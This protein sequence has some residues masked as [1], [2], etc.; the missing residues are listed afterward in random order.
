MRSSDSKN[1]LGNKHINNRGACLSDEPWT[2]ASSGA[3]EP[4]LLNLLQALL[5]TAVLQPLLDLDS[6]RGSSSQAGFWD[7]DPLVFSS[8][9]QLLAEGSSL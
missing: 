3:L 9:L 5:D 8:L 2:N 1:K 4:L 6:A 7:F